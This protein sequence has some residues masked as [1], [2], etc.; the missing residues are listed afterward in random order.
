MGLLLYDQSINLY[1]SRTKGSNRNLYLKVHP[2]LI[3][4]QIN[5]FI[6][7]NGITESFS[8]KALTEK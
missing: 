1:G 4:S 3:E 2:N 8:I 7:L 6:F 5:Y